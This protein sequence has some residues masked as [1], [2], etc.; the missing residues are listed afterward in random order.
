MAANAPVIP[1][2]T[3]APDAIDET[4]APDEAQ[5]ADGATLASSVV[6]NL[7]TLSGTGFEAGQRYDVR[8][9]RPDGSIDNTVAVAQGDGALATYA[10]VKGSGKHE[11]WLEVL[12]KK[13]ASLKFKV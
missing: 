8:F 9:Q 1:D 6:G 11:A 3:P 7:I 5:P 13:I 12:G 2:A 10:T 4:P